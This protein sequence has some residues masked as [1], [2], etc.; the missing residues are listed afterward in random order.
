M[1]TGVNGF[2]LMRTHRGTQLR[3]APGAAQFALDTIKMIDLTQEPGRHEWVLST[4]LMELAS[5][6]SPA[7]GQLDVLPLTGE[8]A[9]GRVAVA[10]H[11]TAKVHRQHVVQTG[12]TPAGLPLV[13]DIATGTRCR[14][15][16]A[17]P[18]RTMAGF[19]IGHRRLIDL[20]IAAGHD[21]RAN[22]PVDRPQ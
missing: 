1:Q 2:G 13:D 6:V 12:R 10:L 18:S 16:V 8:A 19:Q 20:D 5:N 21:A 7:G 9:I 3:A 15:E 22:V 11:D 14:P 17:H 4:G